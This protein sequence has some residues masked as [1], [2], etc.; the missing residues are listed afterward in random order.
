MAIGQKEKPNGDHRWMGDIFPLSKVVF[1]GV[2]FVFL[3]HSQLQEREN[4]LN[5]FEVP[6]NLRPPFKAKEHHTWYL[7]V[8]T[9]SM[10]IITAVDQLV[11]S[12]NAMRVDAVCSDGRRETLRITHEDLEDT[13]TAGAEG[14]RF[15]VSMVFTQVIM[16]FTRV[17]MVFTKVSMVFGAVLSSF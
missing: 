15:R 17:S 9:F 1:L 13:K 2:L 11:G 4:P 5:I 14:L 16:G 10:P 3:I 6:L 7:Q 8:S 12:T